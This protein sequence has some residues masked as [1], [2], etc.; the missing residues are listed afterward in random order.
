MGKFVVGDVV[1]VP[2]PFSDLSGKKLRPAVI[3]AIIEHDDLILCQI[4]SNSFASKRAIKI[5]DAD[6]LDG[7]LPHASHIRPDR[8]FSAESTIIQ[9]RKGRLRPQRLQMLL[10]SVRALFTTE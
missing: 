3:L 4:T 9:K 7:G 8:L 1:A 5:S 6:F 2:F 10:K